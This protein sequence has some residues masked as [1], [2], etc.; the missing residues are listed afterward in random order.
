[1]A[2]RSL[3]NVKPDDDTS[4]SEDEDMSTSDEDSQ[5]ES[6]AVHEPTRLWRRRSSATSAAMSLR[7][8]ALER[9]LKRRKA[10]G[11]TSRDMCVSHFLL[12]L[13]V[14]L[15]VAFFGLPE[16]CIWLS[17]QL[18]GQRGVLVD[19]VKKQV[20]MSGIPSELQ[21]LFKDKDVMI[22]QMSVSCPETETGKM[23]NLAETGEFPHLV[24]WNS[25]THEEWS[26]DRPSDIWCGVLPSSWLNYWPNGAQ[27]I[28]FTVFKNTGSTINLAVQGAVGTM[29][30]V[31]NMHL[32]TEML[33][34][35]ARM[36][37]CINA[38]KAEDEWLV[39]WY[40]DG[41]SWGMK[42]A[43]SLSTAWWYYNTAPPGGLKGRAIF[44][45]NGEVDQWA[46]WFLP[47]WEDK[48]M[49]RYHELEDAD[50]E[51]GQKSYYKDP[52]YASWGWLVSW[53]DLS[54][55]LF[56]FLISN[57]STNTI[58]FGMSWHIFFMMD[59]M[60]PNKGVVTGIGLHWYETDY[61]VVLITTVLG[62]IVAI[63]AT[64]IP[65]LV[66]HLSNKSHLQADLDNLA[67][68]IT[69]VW[70]DSLGYLTGTSRS[71]K[72]FQIETEI[73]ALAGKHLSSKDHLDGAW[74][75]T[76]DMGEN[77]RKRRLLARFG[78]AA[79]DIKDVLYV[80]KNCVL[81]ETFGGEHNVFMDAVGDPARHLLQT[82]KNLM[83]I[84]SA[85]CADGTI[86]DRERSTLTGMQ[87]AVKECQLA[88]VTAFHKASPQ[89]SSDLAEEQ[90][91]LFSLSMWARKT[92]DLVDK[93][94][95]IGEEGDRRDKVGPCRALFESLRETWSPWQMFT[96]D[97]ILFA[98][99]NWLSIMVTFVMAYYIEDDMVERYS[100][101]M[102]MTL[103]LLMVANGAHHVE[104]EK[105][106]HRLL[107][108]TLGKSLPI[109]LVGCTSNLPCVSPLRLV[110]Q[111]GLILMFVT[112]FMF[113]YF[114]SK[115]WGYV[116]CLIAGFGVYQLMVPCSSTG[117][118]DKVFAGKYK[119]LGCVIVA[120]IVQAAIQGIFECKKPTDYLQ[121][122]LRGMTKAIE[123]GFKGFF[124]ADID[125]MQ[126][127][128]QEA[129][130][131]LASA[132]RIAPECNPKL[133]IVQGCSAPFKVEFCDRILRY[134]DLLMAEST[135]MLAAA[136]DWVAN[137]PVLGE[138]GDS[139]ARSGSIL[140]VV[141]G[142]KSIERVKLDVLSPISLISEVL[143]DMIADT[144]DLVE[145]SRL[146][147]PED[148]RAADRLDS[149][150]ELYEELSA[151]SHSFQ[152]EDA[153]LTSD[154]RVRLTIIVRSLQNF[155]YHLSR[156]EE[157][158]IKEANTEPGSP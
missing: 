108:V 110:V 8:A 123:E 6:G 43:E 32:M 139:M 17:Y 68:S 99:R 71:A 52:N 100:P 96:Q 23:V 130:E 34:V 152:K 28:I 86:D 135:M 47:G 149:A 14:G 38:M 1:M 66:V 16:F 44:H 9:K 97:H 140:D 79:M 76:F 31:L 101:V 33:P 150:E 59:F 136:K 60:N 49:D 146:H 105:S 80:V 113:V 145:D 4:N 143:P 98:I 41:A 119:E 58:M 138:T 20:N 144:S 21:G 12:A 118:S 18:F 2:G 73:D 137:S 131:H 51:K 134:L 54:A 115:T 81:T 30:A 133:Q 124:E 85:A 127:S 19:E 95:Q 120:I 78:G 37:P 7:D 35:G 77:G 61:F 24:D 57:S 46:H 36:Y 65:Q 64:L 111:F 10:I 62:V 104:Y 72:R 92:T 155:A 158:C 157:L 93:L 26:E 126:A 116:G 103:S 13:S 29:L 3:G 83:W 112:A 63:I 55:V 74:W 42:P 39:L 117:F 87:T 40:T 15:A 114:N 27:L 45:P 102:P 148:V 151:Q 156:I 153:E 22:Q 141:L 132:R 106:T 88:L 147:K 48:F 142:C 5:E 56:L 53:V 90:L 122:S 75:E 129:S 121:E 94:V 107:G 91:L 69:Q 125:K 84:C 154:L 89:V 128:L 82:T 109:I 70:S 11:H 67:L 25:S 50:C